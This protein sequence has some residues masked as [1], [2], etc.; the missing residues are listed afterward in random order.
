MSDMS[1]L[2]T[3]IKRV[4]AG[5]ALGYYSPAF[6]GLGEN[7]DP[8]DCGRLAF[9]ADQKCSVDAAHAL[10][11]AVL[12]EH[13]FIV[14]SSDPHCGAFASVF[15]SGETPAEFRGHTPG[16]TPARA[17]LLATLKAVEATNAGKE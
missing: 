9:R 7:V 15:M 16:D 8:V 13:A 10:M 4:E 14:V 11:E 5:T 12:P 17:L 6:D 1:A 2:R 3:L